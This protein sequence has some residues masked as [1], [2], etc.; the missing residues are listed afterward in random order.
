MEGTHADPGEEYFPDDVR[1]ELFDPSSEGHG[2]EEEAEEGDG[3]EDPYY[4]TPCHHRAGHVGD[5]MVQVHLPC[6]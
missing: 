3:K 4:V 2:E 1:A 5:F 6:A